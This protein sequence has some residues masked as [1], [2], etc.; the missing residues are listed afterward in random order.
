MFLRMPFMLV[1][2]ETFFACGKSL[3]L[4]RVEVCW[5]SKFMR[6]GRK[7][8]ILNMK[9]RLV[10]GLVGIS[11]VM[12]L[13]TGCESGKKTETE[14][15]SLELADVTVVD[16]SEPESKSEPESEVKTELQTQALDLSETETDKAGKKD[17]GTLLE[18][19]E[20]ETEAAKETAQEE[21]KKGKA[22]AKVTE[23]ETEAET[24]KQT[25]KTASKKQS[26]ASR[27]QSE[28][29]AQTEKKSEETA[30]QSQSETNASEAMPESETEAVTDSETE[31]R[32]E[33]ET[34]A[35]TENATSVKNGAEIET[36]KENSA[37]TKNETEPE[38]E[39]K[40]ESESEASAASPQLRVINDQIIVRSEASTESEK[41]ATLTPGM[42]VIAIGEEGEWIQIRFQ[43]PDGFENGYIKTQYLNDLDQ[44][45]KVKEKINVRKEAD[46]ESAKLGELNA[47]ALVLA[48]GTKK[49]DWSEILCQADGETVTA[50]VMTEFLEPVEVDTLENGIVDEEARILREGLES[51]SET[52][53]ETETESETEAVT[54]SESETETETETESETEAVTESESETETETESETE[55][56]TE[57]ESE[58]E[59]QT[60][61]ETKG[62]S[63]TEEITESETEIQTESETEVETESETEEASEV[64]TESETAT[65]TTTETESETE[66]ATEEGSE[67][68]SETESESETSAE[69][70][71]FA[72]A[73]D[74]QFSLT[75][76]LFSEASV[77]G[78]IYSADNKAAK[79]ELTDYATLA[80]EYGYELVTM[81]VVSAEDID[82]A[83]SELV[84]EV[85]CVFCMDDAT[86]NDLMQTICAYAN[87]VEIPVFG[88]Q[89]AQTE[90]GC[91]A[92]YDGAL[93][94]NT[95]EAEKLGKSADALSGNIVTVD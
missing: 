73:K 1:R 28:T 94:W 75:R 83:M 53:T 90:D 84:G 54:E 25:E 20:T 23:K 27:K 29:T 65:E 67:A 33:T 76:Q 21:T 16:E 60:E 46:K 77:V 69:S 95:T 49:Q 64:V 68:E 80:E 50:Y 3:I 14:A 37:G 38:Q 55:A 42:L 93:Y 66:S 2:V 74:A 58:T 8:Y 19:S 30:V 52:E 87:E 40:T 92:A 32:K 45:Y 12:L 81:E 48:T 10:R 79:S 57:T 11:A 15:V 22:G 6:G 82:F 9:Y 26:G 44:L 91:L 70:L 59:V 4:E 85:D 36:E 18:E 35:A 88:V 17:S 43:S 71:T 89:K 39:T 61:S 13:T 78:V 63:E 34:E 47:N 7:E 86:L 31:T 56:V 51:E 24:V 62:E 41:L 5:K 72:S